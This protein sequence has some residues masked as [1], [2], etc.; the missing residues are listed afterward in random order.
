MG[1]SAAIILNLLKVDK[2]DNIK[3]LLCKSMDWF[4]YDRDLYHQRVKNRK[5]SS[6]VEISKKTVVLT[7]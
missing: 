5:F 7:K 4:L 1:L 3:H 2:L 6:E